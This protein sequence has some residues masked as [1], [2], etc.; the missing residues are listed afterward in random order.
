VKSSSAV[1]PTH[2]SGDND[3]LEEHMQKRWLAGAALL[4]AAAGSRLL[5]QNPPDQPTVTLAPG[6]RPVPNYI[7]TKIDPA[8][9]NVPA[10]FTAIFNGK[11]LTGW[12]VSK[13]A[14]HGITPDFHVAGGM[15]VG[16]QNPVANGGLLL[17]DKSYRSFE[18]YLEAKPDWGCDSGIFFRTTETGV[19]YQVTMD[20]LP[21]GSMGRTIGEGGITF[22]GRA[23]TA[24]PVG[25]PTGAGGAAGRQAA[26]GQ[27]AGRAAPPPATAPPPPGNGPSGSNDA[28][29]KLW[30]PFDWNS[31][32]VRVDGD[33]PHVTVWINDQ[34]VSDFTD[35]ENHALNGMTSSPI[36]LQIHGGPVRWVPGGFWRWRNIGIRELQ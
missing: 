14:R 9:V 7:G 30:K 15:I 29:M 28:G 26:G 20:Y 4:V 32:R 18:L 24:G 35:T 17:T 5:A 16:T 36:A 1:A 10:G 12:H 6:L 21:G 25:A 19:A 8:P 23:A 22:G 11:D 27:G 33:V 3:G 2:G 34:Q 13:T 31:V